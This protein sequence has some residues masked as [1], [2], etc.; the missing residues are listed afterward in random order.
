MPVFVDESAPPQR[1][2][3]VDGA[4]QD[5]LRRPL[6]VTLAQPVYSTAS[7][8]LDTSAY[9]SGDALHIAPLLRFE[10]LFTAPRYSATVLGLTVEDST[11]TPQNAAGELWLFD[12]PEVVLPALNAAWTMTAADRE[13]LVAIVNFGPYYT[14]TATGISQAFNIGIPIRSRRADTAGYGVLVTRGAP[15]YTAASLKLT[16]V[17]LPD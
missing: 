11:A 10:G 4:N 5:T 2:K 17:T 14:S 1:V 6:A 15:T 9:A 3:L 7:P 16:L 8:V 12:R 13:K